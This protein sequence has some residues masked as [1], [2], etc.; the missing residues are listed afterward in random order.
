MKAYEIRFAT[1]K[2]DLKSFFG[3]WVQSTIFDLLKWPD[4]P[5]KMSS[6]ATPNI[7]GHRRPL[8][9]SD[10]VWSVWK[11]ENSENRLLWDLPLLG[12]LFICVSSGNRSGWAERKPS[13][14]GWLYKRKHFRADG[15]QLFRL[16]ICQ[17]VLRHNIWSGNAAHSDYLASRTRR[18]WKTISSSSAI[19]GWLL[20]CSEWITGCVCKQGIADTA[21]SSSD[22]WKLYYSTDCFV[23]VSCTNC[24]LENLCVRP[25]LSWTSKRM[26]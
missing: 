2:G 15:G 25:A 10:S 1:C 3:S 23:Q 7:R 21:I 13:S 9:V 6:I 17:F 5:A 24:L 22:P 14:V 12:Q 4:T 18:N 11:T 20:R 19:F 26:I 16:V 8:C